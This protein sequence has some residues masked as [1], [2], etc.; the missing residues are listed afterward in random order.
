VH[1]QGE[2]GVHDAQQG[3]LRGLA[4]HISIL[5]I[6]VVALFSFRRADVLV[7]FYF[8]SWVIS[9]ALELPCAT[10]GPCRMMSQGLRGP[11]MSTIGRLGSFA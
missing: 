4:L 7:A 6:V 5:V 9:E 2:P 10:T 11:R 3:K 1:G 8:G